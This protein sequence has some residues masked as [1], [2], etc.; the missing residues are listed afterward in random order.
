[1]DE[2]LKCDHSNESYWRYFAVVLFTMLYNV[3]WLLSLIHVL[4]VCFLFLFFESVAIQMKATEQFFPVVL[5]GML[6]NVV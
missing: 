6:Y 2:A 5:F 4:F 1:M 3:V